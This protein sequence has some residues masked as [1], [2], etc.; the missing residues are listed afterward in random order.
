MQSH[1]DRPECGAAPIMS[2]G[3]TLGRKKAAGG[4]AKAANTATASDSKE[5]LTEVQAF[6]SQLGLGGGDHAFDDFAPQSKQKL[7]AAHKRKRTQP[8]N[9][10]ASDGD[11]SAEPARRGKRA[12]ADK[13]T[14]AGK[15]RQVAANAAKVANGSG[16]IIPPVSDDMAAAI[17]ERTWNF[18][19]GPRPGA[20]RALNDCVGACMHERGTLSR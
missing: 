14:A 17:K 7:T 9:D 2:K 11:A 13:A 1:F 8:D 6:A 18:G 15:G 12:K 3:A 5:L 20:V 10:S 4:T 19:V 16:P